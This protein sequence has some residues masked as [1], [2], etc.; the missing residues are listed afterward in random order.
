MARI[1]SVKVDQFLDDGLAEVSL[2]AHFLLLG[3]PCLADSA[4]RIE[5]RP[6]KIQALLFAYRPEIKVD[7][8]LSELVR[9]GHIVRYIAN[10]E[11]YIQVL[12]WDRDQRP[13]KNEPE[14]TIPPPPQTNT[15]VGHV[16]VPGIPESNQGI[17]EEKSAAGIRGM[18]SGLRDPD[19]DPSFPPQQG[20]LP[21]VGPTPPDKPAKKP[22]RSPDKPTDPRH[23][24][25]SAAL[26]ARGW[27]HHG[28]RTATAIKALLAHA[29]RMPET[30]GEGA[31]PEIM[32]RAAIAKA[33]EGYPRVRELHEL[34][35]HWGHFETQPQTA[36]G[37]SPP[38]D[39]EN[40]R[41]ASPLPEYLRS[42]PE[43]VAKF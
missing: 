29:D 9:S 39:F 33:Y 16:A 31:Q 41:P 12:D 27:P 23:G 19:P 18:G 1:R 2:E 42:T 38:S 22:R 24:P 37:P 32:R 36:R 21:G 15:S 17:S 28:G 8:L 34:A 10:G 14:S 6:R 11:S 40:P 30:A 43:E 35:A 20:G 3:L 26:V 13:H 7:A 25:I 5:D 4:G